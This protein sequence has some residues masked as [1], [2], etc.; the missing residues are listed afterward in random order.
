MATPSLAMI[1][2]AYAD[3]KVYSVLPNNGDGDFTFNRDSSA[4]RVGQNGLIQTVGFFGSEKVT[5]GDFATD[6]DWTKGSTTTISNG[7]C[8]FT[9][10]GV[11]QSLIQ[12]NLWAANSLSGKTVKL[13]YT[14]VSNNLNVTLFRVGGFSGA[15]GFPVTTLNSEVGTH[16]V[17]I[18]ITSSG[19][20]DNAID[21]YIQ[22]AATTGALVL[23]NV[24]VKEVLGDQPRLN[25]DI[26]NGVVG[27]CPSLLLE[28]ASTNLVPYSEDLSQSSWLKINAGTGVSP[29]ITNNFA[30]SPDGTQNAS[31]VIL[32]APSVSPSNLSMIRTNISGLASPH[33][34]SAS[35]YIKS[36]TGDNYTLLF[37]NESMSPIQ[38]TANSS[39][40]RIELSST[41]SS[42][43]DRIHLGLWDFGGITS[44]SY[45]DVSIWGAQLEALSYATSYIPTNGASQTR[46]AETCFGAGT[47][48]TF[49]S[50]EGTI[51]WEASA[52]ADDSIDKRIFLSDGSF[53]NYV[54]IGYSRFAGNII[55]EMVAGGVL[56][57]AAFGASGVT[58]TNNNKYA[59]SWGGGTMKFYVN[60]TQTNTE[61]VTSPTGLNVL[62]FNDSSGGLPM[63]GNTKDLRVYN[64]ALTDA[65]LIALTT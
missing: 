16:T 65:Q 11:A 59:L 6:S 5:N 15:S 24:S 47:A 4:T 28:P 26:S 46:A 35:L 43:S 18:V 22:S 1:P 10:S 29:S 36:N 32:N 21:F 55:A 40:Q 63:Y 2:S 64:E 51:Y 54:A 34:S 49:N 52:L 13:T 7:Q 60:G 50:T 53:N 41:V 42:S 38:V 31:R 37:Y 58:K 39:W 57:T 61:P 30:I 19:G 20:T 23:D 56:Q 25:Y 44:D 17:Q 3:S 45:A 9:A 14:I 62:E 8:T 48:S 27:G 33:D 12:G